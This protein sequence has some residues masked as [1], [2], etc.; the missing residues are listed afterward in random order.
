MDTI[1]IDIAVWDHR[2]YD[3]LP[4]RW[5]K[6]CVRVAALR[7]RV[8]VREFTDGLGDDNG[9]FET[10]CAEVLLLRKAMGW[11]TLSE[12]TV[13]DPENV[14]I[15]YGTYAETVLN[16]HACDTEDTASS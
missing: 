15:D 16:N 3:N 4:L 9:Y 13:C 8:T 2:D 1:S 6:S 7:H 12:Y 14:T 10:L 11:F 5:K